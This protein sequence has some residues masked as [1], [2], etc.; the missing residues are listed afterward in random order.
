MTNINDKFIAIVL[1]AG[2][3]TR[4]KP[5]TDFVPKVACPIIEKP[6]AF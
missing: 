1:C 3:G 6:I 2:F 4:L 5:L